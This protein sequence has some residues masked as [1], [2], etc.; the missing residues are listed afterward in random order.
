VVLIGAA[1]TVLANIAPSNAMPITTISAVT[2]VL[3]GRGADVIV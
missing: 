1:S 3:R 2:M